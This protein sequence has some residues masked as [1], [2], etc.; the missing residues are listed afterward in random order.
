MTAKCKTC[1]QEFFAETIERMLER[2]E[3][4]G[5]TGHGLLTVAEKNSGL[6]LANIVN[7]WPKLIRGLM[8]N[9][10]TRP[11]LAPES[12]D[13]I[14][15]GV[16]EAVGYSMR[17]SGYGL[18]G[19]AASVGSAAI[20]AVAAHFRVPQ[21]SS[22]SGQLDSV[23]ADRIIDR[24]IKSEHYDT[25]MEVL[26]SLRSRLTLNPR[27]L[28]D[29]ER[30]SL[31]LMIWDVHVAPV[32]ARA[33]IIAAEVA[34]LWGLEVPE[35]RPARALSD[36]EADELLEFS[37]YRNAYDS[38][39]RDGHAIYAEALRLA[40]RKVEAAPVASVELSEAIVEALSERWPNMQMEGWDDDEAGAIINRILAARS[41]RDVADMR[42]PF[43]GPKHG[44]A[45]PDEANANVNGLA[46]YDSM[47]DGLLEADA[48]AVE[49]SGKAAAYDALMNDPLVE[50]VRW[51]R[52]TPVAV[53]PPK[54]HDAKYHVKL[55][56]GKLDQWYRFGGGDDAN[57]RSAVTAYAPPLKGPK[58]SANGN[59]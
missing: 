21:P 56:S 38:F 26:R 27:R 22:N 41:A 50:I 55:V 7:Q 11:L 29:D 14:P 23:E 20:R 53:L 3:R 39:K 46:A 13:A 49:E 17:D 8:A 10:D 43:G 32:Q 24:G 15:H 45:V 28:T 18:G 40:G 57:W 25:M 30:M 37:T 16:R 48:K 58:E 19:S 42:P 52:L 44:F 51:T 59:D 1:G 35:E 6:S 2:C 12:V 9:A 31:G 5:K 33:D 4:F 34:R 47:I 54:L 36:E